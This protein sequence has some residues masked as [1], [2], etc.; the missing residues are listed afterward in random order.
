MY[1][2]PTILASFDA[3]QLLGPAY[4][5]CGNESDNSVPGFNGNTTGEGSCHSPT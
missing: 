2:R 1:D 5:G 3:E 4:G